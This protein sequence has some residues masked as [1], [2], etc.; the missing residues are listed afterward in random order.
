[1]ALSSFCFLGRI[2]YMSTLRRKDLQREKDGGDQD[3]MDEVE[4]MVK[5][6]KIPWDFIQNEVRD[7][8]ME[9]IVENWVE[10]KR[11]TRTRMS[12]TMEMALS[13]KVDDI[14]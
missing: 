7:E 13:D 2:G 10:V 14:A 4:G 11:R 12:S 6:P 1:M 9:E 5:T 8:L 3:V